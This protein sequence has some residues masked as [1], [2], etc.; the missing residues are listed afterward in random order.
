MMTQPALPE[1]PSLLGL[2]RRSAACRLAA[3]TNQTAVS[4]AVVSEAGEGEEIRA[5][6]V[7]VLI[8]AATPEA[9]VTDHTIPAGFP[10]PPLHVHPAFHEAFFVLEG[11]LTVRAGEQVRELGPGGAAFVTGS[12]PH[13][14]ANPTAEPVRFAL[15]CTPGGF[16]EYFRA[17]AAG[18]EA[19]IAAA[20]ERF[21]YA[22]A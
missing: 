7:R 13:T 19:A 3:M 4:R 17:V 16:E 15:V 10:G 18:D 5:H 8:K 21:G 11:R 14:F 2:W 1:N 6:G 22:P 20:S 12:T 9:T